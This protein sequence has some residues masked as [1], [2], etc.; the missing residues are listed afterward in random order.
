[1]A[2]GHPGLRSGVGNNCVKFV[3]GDRLAPDQRLSDH[4]DRGP[5]CTHEF[6]GGVRCVLRCLGIEAVIVQ[7]PNNLAV[8]ISGA[9]I[10]PGIGRDI[11]LADRPGRRDREIL[12]CA[13]LGPFGLLR[14]GLA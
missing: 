2:L 13:G 5:R 11:T 8:I 3:A 6:D 1:V 10:D 4:L 9:L 7:Q 12:V 14:R